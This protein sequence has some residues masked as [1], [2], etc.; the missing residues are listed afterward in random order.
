[1]SC[2]GAL[3]YGLISSFKFCFFNARASTLTMARAAKKAVSKILLP[4]IAS[5]DYN[6][7][8]T[9]QNPASW[10]VTGIRPF[11]SPLYSSWITMFLM[12]SFAAQEPDGPEMVY[13]V[14]GESS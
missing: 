9:K 8:N 5:V 6:M 7:Y 10:M 1:M 4:S 12:Q 11:W 13:G 14:Y 2:R 3:L